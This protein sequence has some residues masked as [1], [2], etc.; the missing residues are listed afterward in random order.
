MTDYAKEKTIKTS[1]G[2]V[3]HLLNNQPHSWEHAAI[4]YPKSLKKKDEYYIYGI[5]YEKE[6]WNEMRKNTDGSPYYKSA[7]F[8]GERV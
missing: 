7:S 6:N 8:K 3:L 5:K 1:D 2:T 4:I